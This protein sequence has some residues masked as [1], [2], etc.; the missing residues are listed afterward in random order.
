MMADRSSRW[1]LWLLVV[2][3][4]VT[5]ALRVY[6]LEAQSLWSDEGLS[7]YRARLTL[8]ENLSNVIVVPP[9]VVTQDTNPP[10]YFVALSVLRAAAGESEYVLRFVSVIAGVLLVPL[11]YVTG[12]RLFSER[13]GVL[14]ATLGTFSPFLIWYAQEARMYT[15][16]ATLSLASVYLLLRAIDFPADPR[17]RHHEPQRPLADLDRVG[18]GY[19]GDVIHALHCVFL[20]AL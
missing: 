1:T 6:R 2:L 3:L 15:L 4:L 12:R 18:A 13:A 5:F 17:M 9:N 14:A 11:L 16:L 7:L 10:L 8:G 19:S 20:V